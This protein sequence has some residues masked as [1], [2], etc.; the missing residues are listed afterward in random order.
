MVRVRRISRHGDCPYG[1]LLQTEGLRDRRR[2]RVRGVRLLL[3]LLLRLLLLLLLLLLRAGGRRAA[4]R[5]DARRAGRR[6]PPVALATLRR[7]AVAEQPAG[8]QKLRLVHIWYIYGT[9]MRV[10]IPSSHREE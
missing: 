5:R 6:R 7:H 8:G 1:E 9:Y 4:N 10:N 3:L 2:G